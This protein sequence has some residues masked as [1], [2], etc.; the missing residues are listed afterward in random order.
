MDRPNPTPAFLHDGDFLSV[1]KSHGYEVAP[2]LAA[3]VAKFEGHITE[4]TTVLGV[5]YKDGVLMAGD[6]R[7]TAGNL[8]M[9]ERA[10]KLINI[11]GH[12]ILAIAG[13]PAVA[14]EMARVLEHSFK[15]Y[16]RSQL[17][18]MSTAG[19]VRSLSKLLKE[20]LPMTLQGVGMVVPLFGTY[21]GTGKLYFY[22]ALGAQFESVDY[23][24]SG[25]GS[26]SVRSVLHY[27]NNWGDKPLSRYNESEIIVAALRLLDTAA[28]SDTATSGYNPKSNIFPNIRLITEDG[29]REIPE[30]ELSKAYRAEV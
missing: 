26:L 2:R 7:A 29:V 30:S 1:L 18:E 9:Y 12:S 16:Q 20:N 22:D 14:F 15:Y 28:E 25:S 3:S 23:A 11:D 8:V 27:L 21:D 4:G 24:A 19:K 10:E 5:K 6:R 17:Q 13:V